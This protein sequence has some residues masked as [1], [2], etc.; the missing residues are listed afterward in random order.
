MTDVDALLGTV[1]AICSLL[2]MAVVLGVVAVS[3]WY[4]IIAV[5]TCCC[6]DDGDGDRELR[7]YILNDVAV[8]VLDLASAER[9]R[10]GD[11]TRQRA[12]E[13]VAGRAAMIA[14]SLQ[15]RRDAA[16]QSYGAVV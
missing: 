9:R 3:L 6:V 8:D 1:V 4:V 11:E 10:P 16:N 15:E 7:D 2:A 5:C 12:R 14:L 13:E